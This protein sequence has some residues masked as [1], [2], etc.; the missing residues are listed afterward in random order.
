M[1]EKIRNRLHA[2]YTK[3]RDKRN[4]RSDVLEKLEWAVSK[5]NGALL[6]LEVSNV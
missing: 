4:P 3:E 2:A 1:M 5:F 6:R